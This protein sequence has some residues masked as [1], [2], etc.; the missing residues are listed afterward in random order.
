VKDVSVISIEASSTVDSGDKLFAYPCTWV[1][2]ARVKHWQHIHHR[3][4]MYV[5]SLTLQLEDDHWK[6]GDIKIL[7][8]EREIVSWNRS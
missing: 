2:T 6:I 8:E 1:I 7:S 5:G 4:A 3:Q